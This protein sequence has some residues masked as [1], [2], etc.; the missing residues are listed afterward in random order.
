[1]LEVKDVSKCFYD[2]I[3]V[4]GVTFRI[5][6]GE[7][8][9]LIGPNG[10]GKTTL[11]NLIGG[12]YI[13]NK[14]DIIFEG[15]NITK[16]KPPSRR[17][18]LGIARTFQ[19]VKPFPNL[20]V[21][22]NVMVGGFLHTNYFQENRKKSEEIIELVGLDHRKEVPAG[23]LTVAERRRMELAR[24][25][26]TAPKLL[27]LDEVMSGLTPKEVQEFLM[28]IRSLKE[29][30]DLTIIVIEHIMAAVMSIAKRIIVLHHGK[31]LA[32]GTPM[33]VSRD[34]DVIDA[35]LGEEFSIA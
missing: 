9:G 2:L 8:V 11:F 33:E 21:I 5:D 34:K 13:P 6:R 7:I 4:D 28:L 23:S 32:Q 14:G 29:D 10:A 12:K 20:N 18:K 17:S 1:M 22:E 31:L 30:M 16:L 27:L 26:S 24:A 35:Y 25:L 19:V 3:A 15:K